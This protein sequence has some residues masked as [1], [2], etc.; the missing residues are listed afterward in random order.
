MRE[1]KESVEN[2][3]TSRIAVV[4]LIVSL[5]ALLTSFYFSRE[6]TLKQDQANIIQQRYS[7][8]ERNAKIAAL[9]TELDS[10]TFTKIDFKAEPHIIRDQ[11][12]KRSRD[13]FFVLNSLYLITRGTTDWDNYILE[14]AERPLDALK[15]REGRI[16]CRLLADSFR[17][18]IFDEKRQEAKECIVCGDIS[19]GG[20]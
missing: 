13:T 2:V 6:G 17:K 4:S 20:E 14:A 3:A 8:A 15:R 5:V 12:E 19:C 7:D 1:R 16:G 10:K 9:V 18:F 11:V